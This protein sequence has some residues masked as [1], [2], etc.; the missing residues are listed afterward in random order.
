MMPRRR[1]PS[2]MV[3][4][5]SSTP[6]AWASI[7]VLQPEIVLHQRPGVGQ[8]LVGAVRVELELDE[9]LVVLQLGPRPLQLG[10]RRGRRPG[11]RGVVPE[12]PFERGVH[13][14][15]LDRMGRRG[16]G[17]SL[18]LR[19]AEGQRAVGERGDLRR[20]E[21]AR[22]IERHAGQDRTG[23]LTHRTILASR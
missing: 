19:E 14:G 16:L 7:G 20:R 11:A 17:E 4:T 13:Q 6:T 15:A 8:E 1:I 3:S 21:G 5:P 12:Q 23:V 22:Q 2:T 9:L 18:D 10:G